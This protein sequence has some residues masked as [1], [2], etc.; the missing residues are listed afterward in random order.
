MLSAAEKLAIVEGLYAATGSGDFARAETFLTD[1]FFVTEAASLPMAGI[2][3]GK[4][5]LQDLY[6]K[7]MGM[8]DVAGLEIHETTV[9]NEFA[10]TLVDFVFADPAL[11]RAEVAEMFRFRDGKICEI[12]PFYFD[13]ATI[14]AACAAKAAAKD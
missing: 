14:V 9:G 2:Y 13:P 6:T 3:R 12:K 5:A 11:A 7:V 4:T 1:D 8:M 10:V